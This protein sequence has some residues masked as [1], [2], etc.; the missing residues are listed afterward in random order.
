MAEAM[1]KFGNIPKAFAGQQGDDFQTWVERF[2][3]WADMMGLDDAGKMKWFPTL[4]GDAAFAL[5]KTLEEKPV[6]ETVKEEGKPA[7]T[8]TVSEKYAR[9]KKLFMDAFQSAV[10]VDAFR[11]QLASRKRQKGENLA[12]FAGELKRLVAR[13]YPKYNEEALKD[14]VLTHFCDGLSFGK[15]IRNKDP[16][17]IEEAITKAVK[18]ELLHGDS[19][20]ASSASAC[21]VETPVDTKQKSDDDRFEKLAEEMRNMQKEFREVMAIQASGRAANSERY[22]CY[23]CGRQGHFARECP[24]GRGPRGRGRGRS[25][26]RGRGRGQ[27]GNPAIEGGAVGGG[28]GMG[29]CFNCGGQGHFQ[30]ECPSPALNW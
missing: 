1:L 29:T 12:V 7:T 3:L 9:V 11:A 30:R 15:K 26:G 8:E 21:A 10:L 25:R 23:S 28:G 14:V 5:F 20:V 2:E 19:A 6:N 22:G 16:K 13:A 4:L 27:D 17:T 18:Y 24:E